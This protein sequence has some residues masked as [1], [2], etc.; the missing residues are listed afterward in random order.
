MNLDWIAWGL[1]WTTLHLAPPPTT[2]YHPPPQPTITDHQYPPQPT[3]HNTPLPRPPTIHPHTN[4]NRIPTDE[5]NTIRTS[6][7]YK[8]SA[9]RVPT[10]YQQ[11]TSSSARPPAPSPTRFCLARRWLD[12]YKNECYRIHKQFSLTGYKH[13]D[14]LLLCF[15]IVHFSLSLSIYKYS[16]IYIYIY[17]C[18][19]I[20]TYMYIQ[21]LFATF[22]FPNNR[23]KS[24]IA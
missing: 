8:Q 14:V 19:Y 10:E 18:M 6:A 21:I 17:V 12:A 22:A 5:Q 20:Y 24:D 7:E 16:Y 23:G 11:G 9:N 13:K 2:T 3:S 1:G 4:T 15:K